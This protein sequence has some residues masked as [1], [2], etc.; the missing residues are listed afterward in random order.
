MMFHQAL[1][2]LKDRARQHRAD[3]RILARSDHGNDWRCSRL[4][5]RQHRT[6]LHTGGAR[7]NN[8]SDGAGS[9]NDERETL[10]TT[11]SNFFKAQYKRP[12]APNVQAG[13][14]NI[15]RRTAFHVDDV[16][17]YRGADG[18]HAAFR[19][20]GI[21]S[22]PVSVQID[23]HDVGQYAPARRACARQHR[24]DVLEQQDDRSQDC[25]QEG[26]SISSRTAA[27][28]DGDVYVSIVPFAKDV[29]V[30]TGNTG[31]GVARLGP[32]WNNNEIFRAA[33]YLQHQEKAYQDNGKTWT[34]ATHDQVDRLR[35]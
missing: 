30:G 35:H 27:T 25:G 12:E 8:A 31:C 15:H 3:L 17:Q 10:T 21:T 33:N 1:A 11:A 23:D 29:N 18:V 9:A 32:D 34:G 28:K 13:R 19:S 20:L 5:P 7:F 24:F 4:H 26:S 14:P 6:L 16:G 2:F 22:I